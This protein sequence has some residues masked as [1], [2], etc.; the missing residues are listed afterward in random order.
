[1]RS[2]KDEMRAFKDEMLAFKDEMRSFKDEML[3]FKDEMRSFKDEMLAFKDEMRAFK[4]E[5]LTFKD[6]MRSFKDEV[7]RKWGEL[8]NRLGTLVE[9]IV[10][11]GISVV[12]KEQLGLEIEDL[13]ERRRKRLGSKEREMDIIAIAGNICFV[14]DVKS[15]YR[16]GYLDDFENVLKEF[17]IFFPEYKEYR[18]VPIIS[19]LNLPQEVIKLASKRNWLA[20]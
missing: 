2:F 11:P 13:I 14:V 15:K 20:L 12:I 6:E 5:M 8:A 16:R 19:S 9:D 3:A 1:M 4:D 10:A 18:I 17:L 7:N